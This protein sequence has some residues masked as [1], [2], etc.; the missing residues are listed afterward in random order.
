M[1]GGCHGDRVD[2]RRLNVQQP[3]PESLRTVRPNRTPRPH[4]HTE[5]L[6]STD[7]DHHLDPKTTA[8][9]T[10]LLTFSIFAK[11]IDENIQSVLYN[12]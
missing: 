2:L 6:H 4:N 12:T 3:Q 5:R 7:G 9:L 11:R 8:T 1:T 10:F